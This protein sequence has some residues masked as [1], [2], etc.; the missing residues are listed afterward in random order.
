MTGN[1]SKHD[2]IKH[3]LATQFSVNMYFPTIFDILFIVKTASYGSQ[4]VNWKEKDD[5]IEIV[6]Y[7]TYPFEYIYS[8]LIFLMSRKQDI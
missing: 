4:Y 1:K 3:E 8:Y 5:R 7:R 6:V 2:K